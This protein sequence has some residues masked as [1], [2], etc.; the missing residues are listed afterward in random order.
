MREKSIRLETTPVFG[1]M[2]AQVGCYLS[3]LLLVAVVVLYTVLHYLQ[4][5][6]GTE[7]DLY[8]ISSMRYYLISTYTYYTPQYDYLTVQ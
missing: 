2:S 1:E 7:L 3:L 5:G 6:D 4:L 8:T